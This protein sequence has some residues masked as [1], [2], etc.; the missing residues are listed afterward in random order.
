MNSQMRIA[1]TRY[2]AAYDALSTSVEQAQENARQLTVATQIITEVG[3]ALQSPRLSG[4]QKKLI[5]NQ[6]L[7]DLPQ[8]RAFVGVLIEAKRL[9]LLGPVCEQVQMFLE[10]RKGISRAIIT[11]ARV[12][13]AVQ[14]QAAQEALSIRYGKT[15]RATFQVDP[16]L[17][18]GLAAWCNGELLDGSLKT[19]LEK[20]RQE[21]TK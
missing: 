19:R 8:A 11:T 1:A 21:I 6:A 4:A 14:Q 9:N 16:S 20:L 13:S 3:E 18:G 12:L 17:L 10:D 15:I 5:L 7:K 2:A